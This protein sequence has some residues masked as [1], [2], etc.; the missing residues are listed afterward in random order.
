MN[1]FQVNCKS[2]KNGRVRHKNIIVA[3]MAGSSVLGLCV[4]LTPTIVAAQSLTDEIVVTAQKREQNAQDV[5]VSINA[6]SGAEVKALNVE[7]SFDIANYTPGVHIS[8]NLAGQ[9]TQFTIRGVT[10]ND[11]NDIIEAPNAVYLDDAYIAVAQ[12][13][14]FASFDVERVELLKGPQGTLF[15]RNATGGLIHYISVKPDFEATSGYVDVT[16]GIFDSPADPSQ[17]RVEGALNIPFS[18]TLAVRGAI[19]FNRQDPLLQNLYPDSAVG[20]PPDIGAGADLGD[21]DTL[22]GRFTIAFEP[23]D[24]LRGRITANAARS[25]VSTGPY[26]SKS[27]I[28]VYNADGELANVLDTPATESRYSILLDAAG[29]D[30]GLDFGTDQDNNGVIEDPAVAFGAPPARLP[31]ADFFGYIDPDGTDFSFS[32]DFAFE[33]QGST[34]TWGIGGQVEYDLSAGVTLTAIT[35]FKSFDKLLFIDVDAAP[36]NQLANYAAVDAQTFSQEIRLTGDSEAVKWVAGLYYLHIDSTSDNGLKIPGGGVAGAGGVDV[37][38]DAAL[39]TNSYSAFGQV[40]WTFATNW[41]VTAGV[42]VI[43]ENKDVEVSQSL[44]ATSSA[45]TIHQ[46]TPIALIGPIDPTTSAPGVFTDDFSDTHWAGKIQIEYRPTDDLLLYAG[47]NRGV[48][49]G[50][51]NA[52]INGGIPL[53]DDFASLPYDREV[54]VSYEGGF[55]ATILDGMAR[56]NGSLYYY[57]YSDYQAFLFTGVSG[58]VINADANTIGG[59]IEL[60]ANPMEGLDVI[61]GLAA[62][63]ATVEDVPFRFPTTLAGLD[64]ANIIVTDV[65]PVYAPELQASAIVRYQWPLFGGLASILGSYSYSDE[66]FYNLRNFDADKFDAYHLVNSRIGWAPENEMFELSF[67]VNNILDER[68][69]I[70]GFDLA[71]LC[72]CNEISFQPPRWYGFTVRANF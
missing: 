23:N 61:L 29:N 30:T 43:N 70:Q 51:F 62:F 3:A 16:Y 36:A 40:D 67:S 44:Y 26:Q 14:T 20:A 5:G 45:R 8:G 1:L 63:D 15:G 49:A 32:G 22:A 37:G 38:V 41:T 47:V 33:D 7:Q 12:G 17:V 68:I 60:Q 55:K 25:R 18:D 69:G 24:R 72:G 13:Q 59:E 39:K 53:A 52:P 50:S 65:D 6:F 2:A 9:N 54:L 10:Q 56:L 21:D 31:G 28:A 42:R 57:D 48:K 19:L 4:G 27:T 46:G 35:D 66:Y 64:D 71:T 11:F 34:D 58:L